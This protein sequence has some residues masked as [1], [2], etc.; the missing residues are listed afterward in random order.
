MCQGSAVSYHGLL[1]LCP[2]G[3][4]GAY[5]A[6]HK[7]DIAPVLQAVR[8]RMLKFLKGGFSED[9]VK[10]ARQQLLAELQQTA[11]NPEARLQALA[12]FAGVVQG[13]P[14][15]GEQAG[16]APSKPLALLSERERLALIE[17][18]GAKEV[19]ELANKL[20]NGKPTLAIV[21]QLNHAPYLDELVERS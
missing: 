19:N 4:I 11:E 18:V 12:N 15:V 6:A 3:L 21:G 17:R 8:A 9:D 16:K 14:L 5:V 13:T 7:H 1:C 20:L 2:A 10:L